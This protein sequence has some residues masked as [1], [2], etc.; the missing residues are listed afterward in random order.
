[1]S[2]GGFAENLGWF[3]EDLLIACWDDIQKMIEFERLL[4]ALLSS[5]FA[6]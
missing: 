3:Y 6:E 2:I 4:L 5:V 1:M